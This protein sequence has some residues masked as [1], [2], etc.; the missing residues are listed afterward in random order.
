TRFS[1]DWSSDVCSS[2]LQVG[3]PPFRDQDVDI[4]LGVVHMGHHRDNT[5]NV[6]AL[7]HRLAHEDRQVG[8]PGEIARAADAVHHPCA[9]DVRGIHVAVEI[10][11]QGGVDGDDAQASHV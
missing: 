4:V 7:G 11:F 2:D 8:L 5:G 10:E 3:Q 9:A 1:R 6:A